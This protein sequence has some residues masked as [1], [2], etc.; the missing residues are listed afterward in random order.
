VHARAQ[1]EKLAA[2]GFGVERY[3]VTHNDI[4]L[5][6]PKSNPAGIE[7]MEDVA[8]VFKAIKAKA[9][10]LISRD[11]RPGTQIAEHDLWKAISTETKE[12]GIARW[13][14][15]WALR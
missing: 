6:A 3:P 7:G 10:L 11:D 1:E 2:D 8:E 4:Q 5:I 13:A 12:L 15:A 14:K 9:T